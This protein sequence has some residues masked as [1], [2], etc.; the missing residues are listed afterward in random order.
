MN[1]HQ[2]RALELPRRGGTAVLRD[3]GH[4]CHDERHGGV[5]VTVMVTVNVRED[6]LFG[7]EAYWH[8][9]AACW[10]RRPSA[11]PLAV[12]RWRRRH[13]RAALPSG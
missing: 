4:H 11:E 2:R 8:V 6:G 3:P 9:S 12:A 7:R 5:R 1:E 10:P 13:R